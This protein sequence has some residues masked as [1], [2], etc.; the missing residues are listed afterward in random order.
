MNESIII[1]DNKM[2][3]DSPIQKFFTGKSVFLTGS[4]GF[5]GSV[6]VEKLLR[7]CPEIKK[8]YLLIRKKKG[9]D[10]E[11]RFKKLIDAKV[12]K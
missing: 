2:K 7:G 3:E 9:V 1:S 5:L 6:L 12:S 4:T 11:E 8:I 10:V